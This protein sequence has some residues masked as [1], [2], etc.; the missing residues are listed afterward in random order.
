[1]ADASKSEKKG[2][3]VERAFSFFRLFDLAFFLPGF[4]VLE[5]GRFGGLPAAFAPA[6]ADA[7]GT[8]GGATIGEARRI[9]LL[10]AFSY[11]AGLLVHGIGRLLKYI[12]RW[13]PARWKLAGRLKT[14]ERESWLDKLEPE[15]RRDFR[16]YFWY[17]RSVC[18]NT[19]TA[20]CLVTILRRDLC[21]PYRCAP[22]VGAA[23]LLFLYAEF[24]A[25][26][27]RTSGKTP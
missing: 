19:A 7:G 15:E 17:T 2:S 1:M 5:L 26:M 24:D 23:L 18:L 4:L 20:L 3:D 9:A 6:V 16:G 21:W 8:A 11:I 10:V 12:G 14:P 27:R 25:S 22:L 13:W